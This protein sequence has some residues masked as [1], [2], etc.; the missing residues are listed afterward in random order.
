[1][2]TPEEAIPVPI[3]G[4]A[5]I[6]NSGVGHGRL[7]PLIILDTSNR[8]DIDEVIKAQ[9]FV[10]NGEFKFHWGYLPNREHHF[11][12]FINFI[13]PIERAL[14]IEFDVSKHGVIVEQAFQ[15]SAIYIQAGRIGD[16]VINDFDRPRMLVMLEAT[17]AKNDWD[18]IYFSTLVKKF[19]DDG[20]RKKDARQSAEA[21]LK[22]IRE[23]GSFAIPPNQPHLHTS[24][25][26]HP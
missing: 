26:P 24:H 4:D 13:H 12:L 7:I 19:R 16:R 22:L 17:G 6:S 18:R 5:A 23:V 21:F 1:M 2:T 11:T 8:P 14:I 10:P 3:V 15:S 20:L 9:Q 25:R